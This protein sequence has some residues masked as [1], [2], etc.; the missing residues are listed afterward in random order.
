MQITNYSPVTDLEKHID[1]FWGSGW[2]MLPVPLDESAMDMYEENGKLVAE[3]KLPD[4]EKKEIEINTNS[5]F[6]EITAEHQEE[7][8]RKN[9]RQYFFKESS[10]QY[11]RRVKLPANAKAAETEASFRNG[12]LKVS[13]PLAQSKITKA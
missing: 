13:M 2:G 7:K 9:K 10:S 8:E 4:Y 1:K 3:V 6:L 12:V 11:F 5:G